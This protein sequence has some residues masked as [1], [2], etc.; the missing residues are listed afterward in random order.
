M[1][2]ILYLFVLA[3]LLSA[4]GS[5][6]ISRS[7]KGGSVQKENFYAE[8]PFDF[9]LGLIVVKVKIQGEEYDF[10]FDTGAPNV[11]HKELSGQ[12][13][14]KKLAKRDVGDSQGRKSKQ[15]YLK[16]P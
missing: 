6:K 2:N 9:S 5:A 12:L 4:C 3:M 7:L 1:K 10:M 13:K 8:V 16:L 14:H 11:L 15:A